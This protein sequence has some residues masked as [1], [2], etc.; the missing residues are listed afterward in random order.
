M[1]FRS[2]EAVARGRIALQNSAREAAI[3]LFDRAIALNPHLEEAWI[4]KAQCLDDQSER[5]SCLRAAL[6]V[7]P[8]AT[9]LQEALNRELT[10][11]KATG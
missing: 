1:L 5:L 3:P 9:A 4:L 2:A 6:T 7:N 11:D 8:G 10:M